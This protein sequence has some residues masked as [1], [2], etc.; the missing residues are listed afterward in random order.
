MAQQLTLDVLIPTF[1]RPDM[2]ARTLASLVAAPM[3]EG[4]VA[5]VMVI[6][7][8]TSDATN[9]VVERFASAHPQRIRFMRER[10]RGKSRAVNA[11][12]AVTDGELVGI[13]DDD[14]EIDGGWYTA[15]ANAFR[16][17]KV[18]FIGGPCT[19]RWGAVPPGWLP[20]R[21]QGVIGFVD[22][23]DR[24]R[25]FGEDASGILMGGNAVI[26]RAVLDRAGWY[27]PLLG[28]QA[29]QRLLSGEDEDLF[30]RLLRVGA[31]GLYVPA[32]KIYH[33]V[34]PARLTK[35]YYRRWSFWNGVS[36]SIIDRARPLPVRRFGRVPRFL[37]GAA[38]RGIVRSTPTDDPGVR[39]S[40]EL[41]LWHL[42][43]F[44]YGSYLYTPGRS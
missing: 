32:L 9:A 6:Q 26:R 15:V 44:V 10:R 38:L 1:E 16:D 28:P 3:P 8:D 24:V 30:R 11:A 25:V 40:E 2:L 29:D 21:W 41:D 31:Y 5:R 17:E 27:S 33:Y 22:D 34:P 14:E 4:L 42:L 19:P 35:K 37:V 20:T 12:L 18:A 43:G 36:R 23:G 39:F 7:N 13:I